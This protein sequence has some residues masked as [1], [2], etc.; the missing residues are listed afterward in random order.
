MTNTKR[1]TDAYIKAW[2]SHIKGLYLLL[3]PDQ[4]LNEELKQHI[5]GLLEIMAKHKV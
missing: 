3:C 5:N 4:T 2:D 1:K